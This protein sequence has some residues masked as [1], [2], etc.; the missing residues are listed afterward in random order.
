MERHIM[1]DNKKKNACVF[2]SPNLCSWCD[3]KLLPPVLL[4]SGA[5]LNFPLPFYNSSYI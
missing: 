5:M 2:F 3:A 1:I 4:D